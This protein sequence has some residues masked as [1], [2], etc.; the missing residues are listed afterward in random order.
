MYLSDHRPVLAIYSLPIIRIENDKKEK[1]RNEILNNIMGNGK[2]SKQELK[3]K[4]LG[5]RTEDYT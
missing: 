5:I 4:T 1:L 2:I 3:E